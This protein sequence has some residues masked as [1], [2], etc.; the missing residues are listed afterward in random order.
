MLRFVLSRIGEAAVVLLIVSVIVFIFIRLLPGD[1]AMALYGDNI[2]KM[3]PADQLRIRDNLGLDEPLH[4]QYTKWLEGVMHGELGRSYLNGEPVSTIIYNAVGPTVQ[5]MLTGTCLTVLASLLLG[6]YTGLRHASKT[7]V[8]VTVFSYL[9][10]SMPA[11]Y[12]ALLFM[13]VFSLYFGWF[14]IAGMGSPHGGFGEWLRHITLPALVLSLSHIGYYI[15][16]LRNHVLITKE[17]DFVRAL[18]ARGVPY[19]RIVTRHIAPNSALPFLTYIG[20]S[21]SLTMAGSVVIETL[22]SWPG[23]GMLSLKSALTRDYPVLIAAILL[24]TFVVIIGSLLID[25]F[26]AWFNPRIRRQLVKEGAAS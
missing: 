17:K 13:L 4:I 14:P 1:P 11:F 9:L 19:L 23:L 16:L 5:L 15:R 3:T 10:M 18:E 21:L 12:Q 26:C 8:V 25:L 6:T 2:Q 20:M 22:F 7:D 24:G